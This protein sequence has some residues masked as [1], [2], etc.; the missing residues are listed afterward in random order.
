MEKKEKWE[1]FK[2]NQKNLQ[3]INIKLNVQTVVEQC[4]KWKIQGMVEIHLIFIVE[5][6]K[7]LQVNAH[8]IK[9]E[10]VI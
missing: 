10:Q 5:I 4:V 7:L 3:F 6:I 1:E 2:R 9:L 8:H